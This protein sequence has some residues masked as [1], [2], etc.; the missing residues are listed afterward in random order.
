MLGSIFASRL[1]FA[2]ATRSARANAL[3]TASIVV[4]ARAAVQHLDVDVG[5]RADREALEEVVHQLGLQI[6][7]RA[8]RFTFEIDDGVRPAAEIDGRDGQRLVHRH[9]EVAGAVDAALRSPSACE[10]RLA[11]RDAEVLD[12][13]VLIDVEIAGRLQRQV[14]AAVPRE[15]LQ[16]VIE[17]AD[18]GA[19]R[20]SGRWPSS[21]E[22]RA[23]SGVSVVSAIDYRR[24][25][26]DL[27]RSTVERT[28]RRC[29][30]RCRP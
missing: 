25:A 11:E 17:E 7:D 4:M 16:H 19:R 30:R 24:G 26:Q 9:H 3:N 13:V 28:R 18:A 29:A 12:G 6:A 14:E 5:A 15:Q 1:S 8:A 10:H 23:R 22:R 21:V 2:Q 27:L 20:R